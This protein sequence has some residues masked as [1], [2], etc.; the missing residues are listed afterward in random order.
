MQIDYTAFWDKSNYYT[1]PGQVTDSVVS[2]VEKFLKL[3]GTR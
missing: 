1:S 3:T 2:E